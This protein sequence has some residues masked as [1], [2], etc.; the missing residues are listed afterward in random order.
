VQD[1][2]VDRAIKV[3]VVCSRGTRYLGILRVSVWVILGLCSMWARGCVCLNVNYIAVDSIGALV[4]D[5]C[6]I[7]CRSPVI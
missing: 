2:V 5:L 7:R 3:R 1:G 6:I 4:K